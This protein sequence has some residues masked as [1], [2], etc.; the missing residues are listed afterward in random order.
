MFKEIKRL[1]H[2]YKI[3][4]ILKKYKG[5]IIHDPLTTRIHMVMVYIHWI[6]NNVSFITSKYKRHLE[7][8][9]ALFYMKPD[10]DNDMIW[11]FERFT[12]KNINS[13]Y[14]RKLLTY[15]D[16]QYIMEY[17]TSERIRRLVYSRNY[18]D[19]P[20]IKEDVIKLM[21]DKM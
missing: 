10:Y 13:E 19:N 7:N 14:N 15:K 18:V 8:K 6:D 3:Y 9:R 5:V 4:S 1:Y 17:I 11:T 2:F 16:L 21:E 12:I 20:R